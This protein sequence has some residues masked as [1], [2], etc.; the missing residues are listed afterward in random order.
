[1]NP[2]ETQEK[3]VRELYSSVIQSQ[4]VRDKAI[5]E[6]NKVRSN[7][8]SEFDK[9]LNLA[10]DDL[11]L[12]KLLRQEFDSDKDIEQKSLIKLVVLDMLKEQI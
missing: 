11:K 4:Q 3:I 5:E 9:L 1:M 6:Y 7:F 8:M 10:D 12:L 2:I